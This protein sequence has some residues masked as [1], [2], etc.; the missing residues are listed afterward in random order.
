MLPAMR[1]II[2][3]GCQGSG[4][5]SLALKLGQK[6][7]VPVVHLDVL[8][9]RPGWTASDKTGF[10]ARVADAIAGD[11][12]IVDGTYWGLAFDLTLARADIL[13]VIERPRWLCQWRIVWRSA[14]TRNG[15]RPD[16]P[17]GCP[18]QFDWNLMREAWRYNND[19]WP[20]IEAE[21]LKYGAEV[22]VVR[23]SRDGEIEDF[24]DALD[25]D[26]STRVREFG[27]VK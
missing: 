27:R 8:Y 2:V 13:I 19:R 9:W 7:R 6:L 20:V 15:T 3:I 22:P 14:F 16:L 23:L 5:T 11:S 1:K 24:L 25:G 10:R 18:E 12:W 21:R 4:K 26:L 17:E